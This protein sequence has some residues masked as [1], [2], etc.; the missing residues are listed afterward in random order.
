LLRQT[1]WAY[2][3]LDLR[4][5]A[6]LSALLAPHGFETSRVTKLRHVICADEGS[7]QALMR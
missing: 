2:G 6:E 7:V 3:R 4:S 5:R 1:W